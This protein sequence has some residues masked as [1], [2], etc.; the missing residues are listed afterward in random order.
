MRY[1]TT[2]LG[3]LVVV[4]VPR[5]HTGPGWIALTSDAY[6]GK[7]IAKALGVHLD[8]NWARSDEPAEEAIIGYTGLTNRNERP[9]YNDSTHARR[10]TGGGVQPCP[11]TPLEL[12]LLSP[13]L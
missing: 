13:R 7:G 12:Q 10:L 11:S 9:A 3:V 4:L 5:C 1:T 6:W 2:N 8:V